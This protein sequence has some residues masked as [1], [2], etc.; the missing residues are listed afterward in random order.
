MLRPLRRYNARPK[1]V[2]IRNHI[3]RVILIGAEVAHGSEVETLRLGTLHVSLI[4]IRVS[5]VSPFMSHYILLIEVSLVAVVILAR[6]VVSLQE[7]YILGFLF[8][9]AISSQLNL[10]EKVQH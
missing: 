10:L 4:Y 6:V 1:G 7:R 9:V 5:L 2:V 3:I 8:E